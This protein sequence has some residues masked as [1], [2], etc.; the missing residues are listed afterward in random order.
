MIKFKNLL[1]SL[2]EIGPEGVSFEK[3]TDGVNV[4][5][6]SGRRQL[7]TAERRGD[8]YVLTSVI[9][10]RVRAETIGREEL[11]PLI[12]QHNRETDVVAFNLDARGRLV[13]Q[14]QQVAE[15]LEANELAT[16][17]YW[18]AREADR[19]E[20]VLTGKDTA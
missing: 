13:A 12:W 14:I 19:L 20:Y 8:H 10:G 2:P 7:I 16:Y 15:T 3:Q 17:L 9:L 1:R 5:F 18:L 11:L 4:V 6:V